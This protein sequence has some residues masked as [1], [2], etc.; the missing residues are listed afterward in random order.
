MN[1]L[2]INQDV[3]L[4]TP[5]I[6]DAVRFY[7]ELYEEKRKQTVQTKLSMILIKEN[8]VNKYMSDIRPDGL[9]TCQSEQKSVVSHGQVYSFLSEA[10]STPGPW[11]GLLQG[12]LGV[13]NRHVFGVLRYERTK[14][15]ITNEAVNLL[16][17]VKYVLTKPFFS[18]G[19]F[20]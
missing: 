4:R 5:I 17:Q 8:P 18:K 16:R 1:K 20:S 3:L 7:R 19:C 12:Y 13:V 2:I 10:E 15:K 14:K 9:T 6:R 11:C